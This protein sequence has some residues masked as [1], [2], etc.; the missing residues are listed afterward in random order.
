MQMWVP[1]SGIDPRAL[2]EKHEE[3]WS[4]HPHHP[5]LYASNL[6]RF[7][8]QRGSRWV[9]PTSHVEP[10][11]YVKVTLT[12][13]IRPLAHRLVLESFDGMSERRACRQKGAA[14]NDNRLCCLLW[15]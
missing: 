9:E 3:V 4:P 8:F 7:L 13:R 11:G 6:G 15:K 5:H 1:Y 14:K 2:A 10:S 12:R